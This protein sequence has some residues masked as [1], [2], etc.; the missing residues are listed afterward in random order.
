MLDGYLVYTF[1]RYLVTLVDRLQFF[2]T[3]KS[4]VYLHQCFPTRGPQNIGVVSEGIREINILK[5]RVKEIKLSLETSREF[6]PGI[7]KYWSHLSLSTEIYDWVRKAFVRFQPHPTNLLRL[8]EKQL[9][10]LWEEWNINNNIKLGVTRWCFDLQ[11]G[12]RILWS[13]KQQQWTPGSN[14]KLFTSASA[15]SHVWQTL[16]TKN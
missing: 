9:T 1:I 10:E 11:Q 12:K 8:K 4:T 6:V 7:W 2:T 3:P 14:C 15:L 16:K 13:Q 5:C